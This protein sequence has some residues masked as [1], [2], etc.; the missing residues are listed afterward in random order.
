MID[1]IFNFTEKSLSQTALDLILMTNNPIV[2]K[3]ILD[4]NCSDHF[5][6]WF[7]TSDYKII[8]ILTRIMSKMVYDW[9]SISFPFFKENLPVLI[10]YINH[11]SVNELMKALM[12][13][14]SDNTKW[15]VWS[16]LLLATKKFCKNNKTTL[17]IPQNF[18]ET[19]KESISKLLNNFSNYEIDSKKQANLFKTTLFCMKE[20]ML[21]DITKD[22][23]DNLSLFFKAAESDEAKL[24]VLKFFE[25]FNDNE[26]YHL[27]LFH[28]I[29]N[30]KEWRFSQ[31]QISVFARISLKVFEID[32]KIADDHLNIFMETNS[33]T[34]YNIVFTEF[35]KNGL[36]IPKIKEMIL[37]KL[38][39]FLANEGKVE[40]W[41]KNSSK[42][43][44][45]MMIADYIKDLVK[46]PKWNNFIQTSYSKWHEIDNHNK[47]KVFQ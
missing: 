20:L 9:H 8:G 39:N 37:K 21:L 17:K 4:M 6:K 34:F 45:I 14:T 32:E 15:I 1:I 43:G 35:V 38:P 18:N 26:K 19:H 10:H 44:F 2:E 46:T 29:V 47:N 42:I 31:L 30:K 13:I 22:I 11:E 41:K 5:M 40:N 25:F 28:L 24:V 12:Y 27:D 33:N 23:E 16:F 36:T 3:L 7:E